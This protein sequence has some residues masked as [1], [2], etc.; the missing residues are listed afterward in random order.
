MVLHRTYQLSDQTLTELRDAGIRPAVLNALQ[1]KTGASVYRN[2]EFQRVLAGLGPSPTPEEADLIVRYSQRSHLRL[3]R[4]IPNRSIREWLDAA[5]FALVIA[6]L[7]RTFLFA[8]FKIPSS[9]MVPTIQ[10]GDHIFATMFSYGIPIPFTD[11]KLFPQPVQRGDIVIFPYPKDPSVDYIKRVVGLPG[12]TLEVQGKTVVI[13]GKPLDEPY[14]YYEPTREGIFGVKCEGLAF[15]G[16]LTV[17]PGHIFVMGDNRLDSADSRVW[18]FV[19]ERTIKGK[20]RI[21]YWSHDPQE[22]LWSLAG[23]R[24]GRIGSLLR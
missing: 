8:P 4:I 10:V 9:S 12:E 11:I 15:C 16:P 7:V 17:P 20:G 21:V 13:D 1:A 24:L 6:L 18:G 23:Y 2:E 19:D 3:E 22:D 14:A 5:I